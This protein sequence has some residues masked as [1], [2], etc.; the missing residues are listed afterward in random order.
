MEWIRKNGNLLWIKISLDRN[1]IKAS[2]TDSPQ[3]RHHRR[4]GRWGKAAL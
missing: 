3:A 4:S 1:K 2:I